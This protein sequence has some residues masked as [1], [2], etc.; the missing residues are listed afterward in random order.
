MERTILARDYLQAEHD[1]ELLLK[2]VDGYVA[3]RYYPQEDL[4]DVELKC[5]DPS[6]ASYKFPSCNVVHEMAVE[7][8]TAG[9]TVSCLPL[10]DYNVTYLWYVMSNVPV[11][12]I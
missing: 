5:E 6:W 10:Q 9:E 8:T 11:V 1:R 12:A 2:T 4:Q 7:R 3:A